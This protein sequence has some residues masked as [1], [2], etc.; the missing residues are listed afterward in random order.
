MHT[1]GA[2]GN[3]AHSDA[4]LGEATKAVAEHASTIAK[5]ELRLAALELGRKAKALGVGAGMLLG[6]AVLG[7]FMLGYGLATIA[8]ALELALPTWLSLLIVTGILLAGA[9]V[10]AVVGLGAVRRGTPPVPEQAIEQA[11]LT[12]RAVRN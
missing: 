9:A 4:S 8:A 3:G 7:L 6:A 5:L 1:H 2:N 11:R 12:T 10:L